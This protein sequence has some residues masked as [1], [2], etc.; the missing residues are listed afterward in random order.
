MTR[1]SLPHPRPPTKP[2]SVERY[3]ILIADDDEAMHEIMSALFATDPIDILTA[4][5][6][7]TALQ[8]WR[9]RRPDLL[10]LDVDMPAVDGFEVCRQV[11]AVDR[12]VPI[13]FISAHADADHLCC[14]YT[15]D[16]DGYLTKPIVDYLP[17]RLH[18]LTLLRRVQCR[19]NRLHQVYTMVRAQQQRIRS[20]DLHQVVTL[21]E[22]ELGLSHKLAA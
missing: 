9:E 15:L 4:A 17:I 22:H 3:C 8:L 1:V 19:R 14:G 18:I 7:R 2:R 20:R 16:A 21:L 11:R 10:L 12:E 6:G 13:L 5:D